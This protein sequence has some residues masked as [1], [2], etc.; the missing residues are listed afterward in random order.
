MKKLN[1]IIADDDC[2]SKSLLSHYIK[3][4]PDYQIAGKVSN[5]EELIQ[6]VMKEKPEIVLV[7]I[8]MPIV[9]GVEAAKVCKQLNHSVQVIFTTG[10]DEFAVEAFNL[11]AVDY[12]V[13]PIEKTRFFIAL[14]KAK[15]GLQLQKRIEEKQ[16]ISSKLAIKSNQTF[17]YIA[18][19]D[20][21]Y[22]EKNGRKSLI[23]TVNNTVE[24]IESLQEIEKRLPQYFYRSHRSYLV[25]LRKIV[26]IESFGETYLA[27]FSSSESIAHIS[28]LQIQQVHRLLGE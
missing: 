20:I 5:G 28:K 13:K 7:D 8:N 17:L 25:N 3:L 18:I 16:H 6:M 9:N 26:K 19:E 14:E 22:I 10:Y 4:L 2:S 24:T 15:L 27:Y 1:V 23:H 12:L 11:A 21:L